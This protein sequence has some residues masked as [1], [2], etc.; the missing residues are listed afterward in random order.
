MSPSADVKTLIIDGRELTARAG[1]TILEAARACQIE[2][3]TLCHLEGLSKLG[4]CRLCLVEIKGSVKLFPACITP[5]EERMEVTTDSPR[6]RQH[7]RMILEL[8]FAERNHPCAVCVSN[9]HCELQQMGIRFAINHI[10]LPYRSPLLAV[11]ASHPRFVADHNRCILCARCV[12][13]CAEVEG[14]HVW[15]LA[16][17]GSS[18]QI[19]SGLHAP[20]SDSPCTGCGKCVELCPTGALSAKAG[21][22]VVRSK[23]AQ[24]L[25]YLNRMRESS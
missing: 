9:G 4:A 10:D 11:D 14:A 12:R 19:V 18:V 13:V 7:R 8:L 23:N 17:R 25:P 5:V 6:L 24:F 1:E 3:P 16:G 20:W 22:A 2:I 21:L 15:D